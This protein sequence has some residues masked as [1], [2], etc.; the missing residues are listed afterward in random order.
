MSGTAGT[1]DLECKVAEYRGLGIR[2][3]LIIV[4]VLI[5]VGVAVTIVA[6]WRHGTSVRASEAAE[7]YRVSS[8][9]FENIGKFMRVVTNSQRTAIAAVDGTLIAAPVSGATLCRPRR[10]STSARAK[11]NTMYFMVLP[12]SSAWPMKP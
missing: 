10:V 8:E 12:N 3:K 11:V 9:R 6:V 5:T 2:A 1:S 4:F 7:S